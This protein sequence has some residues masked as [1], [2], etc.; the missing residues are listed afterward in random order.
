MD[1]YGFLGIIRAGS[2]M[3]NLRYEL[4]TER[5]KSIADERVLDE[6]F[7]SYFAKTASFLAMLDEVYIKWKNNELRSLSMEDLREL[8]RKLYTDIL[9]ENYAGSY[10][11]ASFV[12]GK[13]KKAGIDTALS[14]YLS[15]I[16]AESRALIPYA[17]DGKEEILTI[18][19]ELFVEI[20]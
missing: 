10:S 18:Y 7:C 16:A 20:Y 15:F 9:P 11:N 2:V 3:K 12:A 4:V 14:A 6:P 8:N 1:T 19:M 13:L 17:F 5:I